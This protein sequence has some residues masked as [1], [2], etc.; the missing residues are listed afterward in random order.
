MSSDFLNSD[1]TASPAGGIKADDVRFEP[2]EPGVSFSID[3]QT[4]LF[5]GHARTAAWN[6][7]TEITLEGAL[8]HTGLDLSFWDVTHTTAHLWDDP[9]QGGSVIA[10][11]F[12]LA[13][14][15][16]DEWVLIGE[17]EGGA[18]MIEPK[19]TSRPAKFG[20]RG[21][22][23]AEADHMRAH[24]DDTFI[25]ERRPYP[26]RAAY[27]LAAH[28]RS[29][30]YVA[31]RPA[32]A[33]D[34]WVEREG[35]NI[36]VIAV[37]VGEGAQETQEAGA[38]TPAPV[39]TPDSGSEPEDDV[40]L[41]A[42]SEDELRSHLESLATPELHKIMES[43]GMSP[44]F[45]N[46]IDA[47]GVIEVKVHYAKAA[48][49][50]PA[51]EPAEAVA[52]TAGPAHP[53]GSQ[54]YRQGDPP[55]Q[56]VKVTAKS[57]FVNNGGRDFRLDRARLE[58]TGFTL[59]H[60][61]KYSGDYTGL[62]ADEAARDADS[63]AAGDPQPARPKRTVAVRAI[64]PEPGAETVTPPEP[65]YP[66]GTV[67]YTSRGPME[68]SKVTAKFVFLDGAFRV[69]RAELEADGRV[70]HGS[71][72]WVDPE[73]RVVGGWRVPLVDPVAL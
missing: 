67:L 64:D 52:V 43:M 3:P 16:T 7:P 50:T 14:K 53:I 32:G 22:W 26:N 27:A 9:A 70:W 72:G 37:C 66:V 33:F 38:S 23:Q 5:T 34:A 12:H 2:L 59:V 45:A 61:F 40:D 36:E 56:V 4:N 28:V 42:L 63:P 8:G 62:Y 13:E 35:G 31:F 46:R 39:S 58:E 65:A 47:I 15:D 57:V 6:T 17:D 71:L 1:E 25:I 19:K 60:D 41:Y 48:A 10:Y 49:S 54:L 29:G 69:S 30:G 55:V 21:A 20:T 51:P 11:E 73:P 24:P 44:F 18:P 68:V